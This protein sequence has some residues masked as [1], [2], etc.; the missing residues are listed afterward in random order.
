MIHTFL[1]KPKKI[2]EVNFLLKCHQNPQVLKRSSVEKKRERKSIEKKKR[3]KKRK[4][5][6]R[7]RKRKAPRVFK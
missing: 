3:R 1:P 2:E 7:G 4:R 5:K 6:K